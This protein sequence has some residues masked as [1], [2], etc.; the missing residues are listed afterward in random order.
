[1]P[2][3]ELPSVKPEKTSRLDASPKQMTTTTTTS[4]SI[5][6]CQINGCLYPDTHVTLGHFCQNCHTFG[7]GVGHC[8]DFHFYNYIYT[9]FNQDFINEANRCKVHNCISPY[10]HTNQG[11]I[12]SHCFGRHLEAHCNNYCKV[13]YCLNPDTHNTR[14][15][16]CDFCQTYGHGDLECN[17]NLKINYLQILYGNDILP[18]DQHCQVPGCGETETHLTTVHRCDGAGIGIDVGKVDSDAGRDVPTFADT[19]DI[20]D[21]IKCRVK[22]CRYP[23][24]HFTSYHTCGTCHLQGH[25]Q[26]ECGNIDAIKL[27]SSLCQSTVVDNDTDAQLCCQVENC[28]ERNTHNSDSHRFEKIQVEGQ[29]QSQSQVLYCRAKGCRFNWSHSTRYHQCGNCH[30]TGHGQHECYYKLL[31]Y[32]HGEILPRNLWCQVEKCTDRESHQTIAH[33]CRHCSNRECYEKCNDKLE[34]VIM[35]TV[36]MDP[37]VKCSNSPGECECEC[38][39]EESQ[40]LIEISEA[41]DSDGDSDADAGADVN[42]FVDVIVDD[43]VIAD[44]D[45]VVDEDVKELEKGYLS[46]FLGYVWA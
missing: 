41:S 40:T 7:H 16:Y 20:S 24:T 4:T 43:D 17:D 23:K 18:F 39:K 25:G 31:T 6:T 15:H 34:T 46:T 9:L 30:L 44:E 2:R 38:K 11:H 33:R 35:E 36:Q 27:L 29:Q 13:R 1:M 21:G 37:N 10:R 3:L 8:G 19:T 45:V 14:Y 22:N 28:L 26:Q 32:C 5:P 42:V 12:C